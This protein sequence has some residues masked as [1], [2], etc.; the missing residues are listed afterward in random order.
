MHEQILSRLRRDHRNIE[1][2]LGI[3]HLQLQHLRH[4]DYP[5]VQLMVDIVDYLM[6]YPDR[7][8]HPFEDLV[9]AR[10]RALSPRASEMIEVVQAQ[11]EELAC[12]GTRLQQLLHDSVAG[13]LV[14]RNELT[15]TGQRYIRLYLR[16]F[17][18]E[19]QL[20]FPHLAAALR[21]A[22]WL[23]VTAQF[24]WSLDPLFDDSSNATY[25]DLRN[26]IELELGNTLPPNEPGYCPHCAP[27]P[28]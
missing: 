3:L 23:Q 7:Y 14:S 21:P 10:L 5:D 20:L 15:A 25:R 12:L 19:E 11:H 4:A 17:S 18:D 24:Q 22:D 28:S 27:S 8:H 1:A 16:H 9:M 13:S 6:E 2:L 26:R